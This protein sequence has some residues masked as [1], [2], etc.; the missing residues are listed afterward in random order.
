MKMGLVVIWTLEHG[1]DAQGVIRPRWF[2]DSLDQ[3]VDAVNPKQL[4]ILNEAGR[5]NSA[6]S[7]GQKFE[8]LPP[9]DTITVHSSY[10]SGQNGIS[11]FI[12]EKFS[13]YASPRTHAPA[14]PEFDA[15]TQS[16]A[17]H[18]SHNNHARC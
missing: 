13:R 6:K 10:C 11:R 18:A 12:L 17:C 5:N 15:V 9:F 2:V 14:Y 8:N 1:S 3:M 4:G 7:G 16:R